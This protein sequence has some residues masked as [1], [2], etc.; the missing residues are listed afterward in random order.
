MDYEEENIQLQKEL[1]SLWVVIKPMK[2]YFEQHPEM[3]KGDSNWSINRQLLEKKAQSLFIYDYYDNSDSYL[4]FRILCMQYA[5]IKN[6][7]NKGKAHRI[8]S[9]SADFMASITPQHVSGRVYKVEN[10][11]GCGTFCLWFVI[12]DA[13]I[14]FIYFLITG[15]K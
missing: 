10:G 1:D 9:D 12:I 7:L 6:R 8:I 14:C 11:D 2:E 15:G 5:S 4:E 13:L 3:K